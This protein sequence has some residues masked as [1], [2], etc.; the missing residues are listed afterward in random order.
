[1]VS[2]KSLAGGLTTTGVVDTG[3]TRSIIR[4]DMTGF[5]PHIIATKASGNIIQMV[6]GSI[7]D[8]KQMI[9]VEVCVGNVSF[10]LE[11]LVLV[12][13]VDYLTLGM[14]FLAKSGTTITMGNTTVNITKHNEAQGP[15]STH[16]S[17]QPSQP[18]NA[19]LA[20]QATNDNA[21]GADIENMVRVDQP[22]PVKPKREFRIRHS[23]TMEVNFRR[24]EMLTAANTKWQHRWTTEETINSYQNYEETSSQP[25][26]PQVHTV[27]PKL[28]TT[29]ATKVTTLN[30]AESSKTTRAN[31]TETT[32]PKSKTG[33]M[34]V[35]LTTGSEHVPT[36][37]K[38]AAI[39]RVTDPPIGAKGASSTMGKTSERPAEVRNL[40]RMPLTTGNIA[41]KAAK[42]RPKIS[43]PKYSTPAKV[44]NATVI[45]ERA[46]EE[47][48]NTIR[49]GDTTITM[50]ASRKTSKNAKDKEY[51]NY[52]G[53][54]A[55]TFYVTAPKTEHTSN[56][57]KQA[58]IW[59]NK[60]DEWLPLDE[61]DPTTNLL[62]QK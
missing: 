41:T 24:L 11:L 12:H 31:R 56:E 44:I 28:I 33:I 19:K 55:N 51:Q 1:M 7:R 43:K 37:T 15:M 3:A 4:K 16:R 26:Q 9:T 48:H 5:I 2:D 35:I 34:A 29:S 61:E 49:C 46:F 38:K 60:A 36:N 21:E 22:E 23:N 52:K 18:T 57:S 45:S 58:H 10:N 40:R 20:R 42:T 62:Q 25:K 50:T 6:D 8:S 17:E 39:D 30:H 59:H 32:E 53:K 54:A 13:N 47:L 14:D 27:N